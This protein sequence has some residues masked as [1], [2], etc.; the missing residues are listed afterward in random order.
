MQLPR[1]EFLIFL[2]TRTSR[3]SS[4]SALDDLPP[5]RRCWSFHRS[6]LPYT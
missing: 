2:K 6:R 4:R 5:S 1:L 3:G